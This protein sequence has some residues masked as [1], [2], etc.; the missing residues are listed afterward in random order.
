MSEESRAYYYAL[1][2]IA[3][4]RTANSLN[5]RLLKDGGIQRWDNLTLCSIIGDDIG[6]ALEFAGTE[7][8]KHYGPETHNGFTTSWTDLVHRNLS[9][10]DHFNLAVWQKVDGNQ[11]LVALAIGTPSNKRTYLTLK[12]IERYFGHSYLGGRA[13]WPILTCAEEYARL[14]ECKKILIK[15]PVDPAKYER[16]GYEE[17]VHPG[18]RLGGNYLG[19]D[20]TDG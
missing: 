7:W 8:V 14:L 1:Q 3:R 15:D 17:F 4:E 20:M 2:N 10:T 13:L 5:K 9:D 16:Y 18:V 19:K 11:V 6:D 12:W